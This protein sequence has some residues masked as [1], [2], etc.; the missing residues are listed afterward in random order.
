[1]TDTVL[2][3]VRDRVAHITLNRPEALNAQNPAM[4]AALI[5]AFARLDADP[6]VRAGVLSGAGDRAFSTGMDLKAMDSGE[7]DVAGSRTGEDD[8][9][10]VSKPLVAAVHGHCLAGGFELA[11][12]CDIRIASPDARFGMPEPRWSLMGGYGLH[13]LSRMVPLGEALYLQLTGESIDAERAHAIGLVQRIV[14]REQLLAEATRV[15]GL[16]AA[17]APL[18][19]QG[20][21]QVVRQGRDQPVVDSWRMAL[22]IE[23][24]VYRSADFGEGPRAFAEKR[25]PRWQGR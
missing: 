6:E 15:A 3:T 8:M 25:P 18:A 21:K 13:H 22:P 11:L 10:P 17:N 5:E 16:I 7:M 24:A 2:Y 19:V 12:R 14:P 20:I 4:L 9:P 1:M 23:Q